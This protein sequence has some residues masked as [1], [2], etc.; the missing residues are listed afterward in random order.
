MLRDHSN[1]RLETGIVP[2]DIFMILTA[3]VLCRATF[4]GGEQV[5]N[6]NSLEKIC[7]LRLQD[8]ER[9]YIIDSNTIFYILV[10]QYVL[11]DN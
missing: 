6:K 10:M 11:I 2:V 4:C 3:L 9:I 7:K 8:I 1:I 5:V